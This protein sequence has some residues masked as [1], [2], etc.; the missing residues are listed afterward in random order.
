MLVK[1]HD[2]SLIDVALMLLT[3][4]NCIEYLIC[5]RRLMC[6]VLE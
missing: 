5:L 4:K 2:A 6:D 3:N 1:V